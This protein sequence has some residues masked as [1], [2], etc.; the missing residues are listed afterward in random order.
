MGIVAGFIERYQRHLYD[1]LAICLPD[2]STQVYRKRHLVFWEQFRFRPGRSPLIISSPWGRVGLAI[3]ADM[4]YRNIWDNYRGRIDLGIIASAWPEFACRET[5]RKHWLFG[6]LGP[7]SAEIPEKVARDLDIPVICANQCGP[8]RTTIPILGLG[9]TQRI[10]DR[11]AGHSIICDGRN[12]PPVSAGLE[13]R[14]L[15]AE[16]TVA[17]PRGLSSCVSMFPSVPT[18]SCSGS[19]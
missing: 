15:L 4:I 10:E 5:G 13:P 19:V 8:T 1:S 7:L 9:M 16:V 12:N 3:C 18:V 6:R 2:G 14:L 17:D 11:F